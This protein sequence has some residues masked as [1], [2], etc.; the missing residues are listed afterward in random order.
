MAVTGCGE[1]RMLKQILSV[2]TALPITNQPPSNTN[3][4]TNTSTNTNTNTSTNTNTH[5]YDDYKRAKW[6]ITGGETLDCRLYDLI[7]ESMT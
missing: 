3:T 6:L 2:S 5:I 1:E 4:N 7:G